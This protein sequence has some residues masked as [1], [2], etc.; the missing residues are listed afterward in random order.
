MAEARFAHARPADHEHRARHRLVHRLEEQGVQRGK[1]ALAPHARRR[2]PEQRARGVDG[3][4]DAAEQPRVALLH[5]VE[6]RIQEARRAL[7]DADARRRSVTAFAEARHVRELLLAHQLDGVLDQFSHRRARRQHAAPRDDGHR[8]RREEGPQRE[9]AAGREHRRVRRRAGA[10]EG[11]EHRAVEEQIDVP[12]VAPRDRAQRPRIDGARARARRPRDGHR[13][14]RED[15]G[16]EPL[17]VVADARERRARHGGEALLDRQIAAQRR[18]LGGHRGAVLGPIV[19]VLREHARE[20]IVELLRHV[21]AQRRRARRIVERDLEQHGEL[22]VPRERPLP[23]EARVEHAAEREHVGS[24]RDV[25]IAARLLR[26]HEAHGADHVARVREG[27]LAVEHAGDPEVEDA[28]VRR[29]PIGEEEVR[30]LEIAVN[31]AERVRGPEGVRD[32]DPEID[33]GR[34]REAAAPQAILEVLAVEPLHREE[35]LPFGGGAVIEVL[36]D[37]R[38]AE[39]AEHADLAR[40]AGLLARAEQ[41]LHSDLAPRVVARAEHLPHAAGPG[42]GFDRVSPRDP[43][44]GPHWRGLS[45]LVA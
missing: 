16:H 13:L 40:E 34:D 12:L 29:P 32:D 11:H 18:Q 22:I 3:V 33:R 36:H 9:R 4:H 6:R 37:V 42:Q 2:P 15:E 43:G 17:L 28:R 7:V 25:A 21:E 39:R 41:H 14:A 5:D 35:R 27:R 30:G 1:L 10:R 23:G 24:G 45:A 19:R 44:A 26:G 38:V 8:H 31:H 20:E